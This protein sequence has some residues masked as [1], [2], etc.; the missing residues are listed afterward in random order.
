MATVAG[1][2]GDFDLVGLPRRKVRPDEVVRLIVVERAV[3]SAGEERL[4]VLHDLR[5]IGRA[6]NRSVVVAT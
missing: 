5:Q 6:N 4:A 2:V 3:P 1:V